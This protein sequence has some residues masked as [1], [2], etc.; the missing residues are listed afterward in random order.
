M[1]AVT[2][3]TIRILARQA[4]RWAI[5]AQQDANPIIAALHSNYGA[6]Y[7]FAL[8]QVASDEQVRR[9][10]G[11]DAAELEQRVVAIQDVATKR[12]ATSCPVI[13][14]RGPLAVQAGEGLLGVQVQAPTLVTLPGV[15]PVSTAVTEAAEAAQSF[16]NRLSGWERFAFGVGIVGSIAST[17]G[18]YL[19]LRT[20]TC[21][22]PA[23]RR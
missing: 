5:A 22:L 1:P 10:T 17:W 4:A 23:R 6:S 13:A 20:K 16:W 7:V 11:I 21:E 8:R 14:P 3:D 12:L 9:A 2:N 15:R 18:L 19:A